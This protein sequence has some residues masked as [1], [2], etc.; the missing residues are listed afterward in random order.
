MGSEVYLAGTSV[1]S[2]QLSVNGISAEVSSW[3]LRNHCPCALCRTESGQRT[4]MPVSDCEQFDIRRRDRD[5]VVEIL[6]EDGHRSVFTEDDLVEF[7]RWRS[8]PL[9]FGFGSRATLSVERRRWRPNPEPAEVFEWLAA[10]A[11]NR[12]L[13][14]E[15]APARI[16]VVGPTAAQIAPVMPT[17][18]GDTWLVRVED[19][20]T[21]IAYTSDVLPFHQDLC[22]YETPPGLQ[23]LHCVEFAAEVHGGETL[24]CDGLAAA[25]RVRAEAP[26]DFATLCS[27]WATFAT[28]NRDQ[29]MVVRKTHLALDDHAN[30]V[31]LNWAPPFEGP[32][33]GAPEDELRYRQAYRTFAAAV[34]DCPRLALRLSPG[35]IVIFNNRRVLHARRA[36]GQ[37]DGVARRVLEGCYLTADDVSNQY[38]YLKR[39]LAQR[40]MPRAELAS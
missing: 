17:I 15:G 10:L 26:E 14:L 31:A 32:F 23:L 34:D 7:V 3:W 1:G 8:R 33:A 25:E 21:N 30:L 36:Y 20:P 11:D 38:S 29:L 4:G 18:Y 24:F 22:A 6:F 27:V 40:D 13:V 28:I 2:V 37:H 5:G 16:G 9:P 12:I 39:R 35:E 19:R